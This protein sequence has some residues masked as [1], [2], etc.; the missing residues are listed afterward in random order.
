MVTAKDIVG[1]LEGRGWEAE[2]VEEST[3]PALIRT[4]PKGLMK[5]VDGRP[6]DHPSMD[7][8][9]T[10]GGVYAI[11]TNRG[12]TDIAGLKK[13]VEEVKAKGFVPSVH[14]DDHAHP[15]PMG[16]GFFKLWS[17][18][19]LEGIAP[20]DFDSEQGQAAVLEAGGV[21]EELSGAHQEKVVYIN[22]VPGTTLAPDANNQAFVVDAWIAGEFDLD[23]PKY[24][25][26][27]ASTVE[28][29]GGPLKA[30]L[31]VPSPA[32]T[33]EDIVGVLEGRGW[34]ADIVTQSTVAGLIDVNPEGLMKCVDGRPSNHP[35]MNGPK[36]LGGVYAIATNRGVTDIH[37]LKE[38]VEEVKK[39]GHVPSVHG[40]DHAHPAPMGCGFF[41]LWSQ[42]KLDGIAPPDFNSEE[43]QAAV[44][45][46][47]GVYE[48]LSGA[49]EEKVVYINFV[50]NT[51]IAPK[52]G[53]QAFVVDAWIAGKYNL[54]VPKY[55]IA[56]ASTVEQLK[57]PLK[58]KLIVPNPLTP[59]DV[60]GVPNESS[61]KATVTGI[62]IVLIVQTMYKSFL[63]Q[64]I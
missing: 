56:A 39:S 48:E 23:I 9:K 32:L 16:C 25:T 47:G 3:V 35:G 28:Q 52:E 24:L 33:P 54:D 1:V 40:D 27:A 19:K 15:A 59:E 34:K 44:L 2:I 38:I 31:I 36:T 57:G 4:S 21:Y 5:C 8:P 61:W 45:E 17:Q 11:T 50:P 14:G 18:G 60:V 37:G 30:K 46:A 42:G 58:A 62:I 26:A 49:H 53:N 13:V 20:P 29:L 51:T 63:A 7:G 43:G 6:S 64:M 41:K 10:L 55:L 22:L 12:V